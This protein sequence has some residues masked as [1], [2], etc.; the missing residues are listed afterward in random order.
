MA[1][2]VPVHLR[3]QHM[4]ISDSNTDSAAPLMMLHVQKRS[5]ASDSVH[6]RALALREE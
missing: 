4:K 6:L 3:D 5:D 2:T 1:R